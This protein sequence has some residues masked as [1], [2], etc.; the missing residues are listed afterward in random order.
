M[1]PHLNA[2]PPND[3]VAINL[4]KALLSKLNAIPPID[5]VASTL[6]NGPAAV[7]YPPMLF[8]VYTKAHLHY[9]FL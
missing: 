8:Q 7:Y 6:N 3:I 2:T 1:Q 4:K 9:T 5:M